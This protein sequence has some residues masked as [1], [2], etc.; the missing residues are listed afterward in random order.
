MRDPLFYWRQNHV[1]FVFGKNNT[2]K[3]CTQCSNEIK[4]TEKFIK[5]TINRVVSYRHDRKC[6]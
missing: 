5:V 2:M 1:P 3:T 6:A 4:K